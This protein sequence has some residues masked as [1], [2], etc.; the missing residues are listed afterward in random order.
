MESAIWSAL[1]EAVLAEVDGLVR[2][3]RRMWAVKVLREG[4]P[5]PKPG[6]YACVDVVAERY[7]VLRRGFEGAPTPPLDLDVLTAAV[8]ALPGRLV[9]IE[10]LWDGDTEGWFVVLLALTDDPQSEHQLALVGMAATSDCSTGLSRPGPRPGRPSGWD[11]HLLTTSACRSTSPAPTGPMT[12]PYAGRP[13]E[14]A[15]DLRAAGRPRGGEG[16]GSLTM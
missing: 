16:P 6:L 10:A 15:P 7:H 9:A 4:C 13:P 5:E 2:Q 3:D 8:G 14:R 1:S 12:R 11:G